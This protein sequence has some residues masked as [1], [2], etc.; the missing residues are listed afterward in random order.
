MKKTLTTAFLTIAAAF[1]FAQ[2]AVPAPVLSASSLLNEKKP[3]ISLEEKAGAKKGF[4]YL[5]MGISDS[6]PANELKDV[7]VVPGLGLGY[8]LTSG[9]SAIDISASYNRRYTR[10][11]EGKKDTYYYTLPKANYL[12]YISPAKANSFYAGGGL[13]WGGLKTKDANEFIGLIPNVAVGYEMNRDANWKSFV[14]L[15]VSQPAVAA[16][17]KGAFPGPLAE[18]SVGAGF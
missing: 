2:E 9:P 5:R 8:R 10:D 6:Y 11:D 12:H 16:A 17:S 18:L 7:K 4:T 15:D 1:G 14:Q 13:A 3:V